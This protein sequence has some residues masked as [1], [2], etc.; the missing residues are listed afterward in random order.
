MN[1]PSD[2]YHD[3]SCSSIIPNGADLCVNKNDCE[4]KVDISVERI[5]SVVIWGHV[6][7]C[8]NRPVANALVKAL[9]YINDRK[10]ELEGI[11]HTYTD[12]NGFYQFD[13]ANCYEG[14]YR[15]AVSKCAYGNERKVNAENC[16]P[17]SNSP[18]DCPPADNEDYNNPPHHQYTPKQDHRTN[19]GYN[20]IR[21]Q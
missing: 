10:N 21:Y 14:R 15:V 2:N 12:C 18:C 9:K 5:K 17:C 11:C 6:L 19:N 1:K 4:I 13:L 3:D 16:R 7:D 20:N 8:E